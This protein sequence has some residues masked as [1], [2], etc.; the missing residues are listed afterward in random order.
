MRLT[1]GGIGMHY[2]AYV[3]RYPGSNGCIRM[4]MDGVK[5]IFSKT[6]V[7]TPVQVTY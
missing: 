1:D 7:G 6:K 2:S 3:H 5:T 4:P